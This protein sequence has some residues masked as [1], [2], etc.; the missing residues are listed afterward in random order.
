MDEI[1]TAIASL[2][3]K[4]KELGIILKPPAT[5]N[6]L[7]LLQNAFQRDLPNDIKHFY[8][9]CNGIDTLDSLFR[10]L[11]INDI[12]ENRDQLKTHSFPFAEY[13]IFSDVWTLSLTN[14]NSYTIANSNHGKDEHVVLTTSLCE[15]LE[16]YV[17]G[18]LFE[19]DRLYDWYEERKQNTLSGSG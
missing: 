2:I 5:E 7:A 1:K 12:L 10:I 9:H 13:M 14:D 19:K 8:S 4:P 16:R 3:D 15:F 17:K 18:G 11:S 6:E